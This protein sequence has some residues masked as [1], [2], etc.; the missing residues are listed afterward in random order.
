MKKQFQLLT[1]TAIVSG[2]A[3]LNA[4][5]K[6]EAVK[7]YAKINIT[8]VSPDAP[9]LNFIAD[10]DTLN[11]GGALGY[12]SHTGYMDIEAGSKSVS[13]KNYSIDTT[14]IDSTF[15][16]DKDMSYSLYV[17]DSFKKMSSML[18]VDDVP[19]AVI[20]KAH[21]RL[22]YLSPDTTAVTM[23]RTLGLDS[24]VMFPKVR[25]KDVTSFTAINPGVYDMQIRMGE[26]NDTTLLKLPTL[27]ING[28]KAYTVIIVGF[29]GATGK[30]QYASQAFI[31]RH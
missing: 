7:Q 14:Y 24:V 4:C 30:M 5:K 6:D 10:K 29:K 23:I 26:L 8:H 22:I 1:I 12:G 13:I 27:V 25:F 28:Q 21:L 18:V 20:D 9:A 16:F 2:L 11:K 31:N 19:S 15:K 3:L 17:I